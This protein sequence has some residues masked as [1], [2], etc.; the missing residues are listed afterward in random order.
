MHRCRWLKR[1]KKKGSSVYKS[2]SSTESPYRD[3]WQLIVTG[4]L[5]TRMGCWCSSTSH[6]SCIFT[7]VFPEGEFE[8][9]RIS[10]GGWEGVTIGGQDLLEPCWWGTY[11][12]SQLFWRIL[13]CRS[14]RFSTTSSLGT[15]P[16]ETLCQRTQCGRPSS[17]PPVKYSMSHMQGQDCLFKAVLH[18]NH[19][20]QAQQRRWG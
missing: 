5:A 16:V 2:H 7:R 20:W 13:G 17:S 14:L 1:L 4:L 11:F 9:R 15:N 6:R 18:G 3:R 8:V 10:G 12:F 19:I